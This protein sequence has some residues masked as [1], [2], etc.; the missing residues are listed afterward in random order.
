MPVPVA[1]SLTPGME[2]PSRVMKDFSQDIP[3]HRI[4]H[5]ICNTYI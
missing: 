4:F 3:N 1:A 2:M 5:P